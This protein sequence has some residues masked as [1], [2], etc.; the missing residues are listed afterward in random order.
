MAMFG[1]AGVPQDGPFGTRPR[2]YSQWYVHCGAHY[3]T[4]TRN[5]HSLDDSRSS[6]RPWAA[7]RLDRTVKAE[8]GR[9]EMR[10]TMAAS[11][12]TGTGFRRSRSETPSARGAEQQ[13]SGEGGGGGDA[14]LRWLGAMGGAAAAG[15]ERP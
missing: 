10:D 5:P 8:K 4:T 7:G 12:T 15:E 2:G 3:Q 11:R 6:L 14:S 9:R 13:L 1:S